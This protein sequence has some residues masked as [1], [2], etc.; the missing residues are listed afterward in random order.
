MGLVNEVL[1]LQ[2]SSGFEAATQEKPSW[3]YRMRASDTVKL[4]GWWKLI[5]WFC[6]HSNCILI[7][8][9]ILLCGHIAVAIF[10][11][12]WNSI[13][14][15]VKTSSQAVNCIQESKRHFFFNGFF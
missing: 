13:L 14:T 8:C 6:F 12:A 2:I 9:N 1:C 11:R 15:G 5:A 3:G 4:V 7:N 10:W